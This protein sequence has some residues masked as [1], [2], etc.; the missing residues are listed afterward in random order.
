MEHTNNSYAKRTKIF[1]M[2]IFLVISIFTIL[3]S[4]NL[5]NASN[6]YYQ[7]YS[8]NKCCYFN[9]GANTTLTFIDGKTCVNKFLSN[10]TFITVQSTTLNTLV[11]AGGGGG[12]GTTDAS[13]GGGAGGFQT[14]IITNLPTNSYS[15][16]VGLGGPKNG[17]GYNSSFYNITSIGGGRG[18][19]AYYNDPGNGGSGGGAS[20]LGSTGAYGANGTVGQ[21][22]DGGD[23][24]HNPGYCGGGGGG[25]GAGAEGASMPVCGT[26]G[27]G[28]AGLQSNITGVNTYYAGGGGASA[29]SNIGHGGLGGGGDGVLT[30]AGYPGINGTGG[31]GGA[32]RGS[33][34]GV[35]GSGIVVLSYLAGNMPLQTIL[36]S[37]LNDSVTVINNY[38][39]QFT[40]EPN[41][42]NINNWTF[43]IWYPNN[44]I[45]NITQVTGLSTPTT[46]NI[47]NNV[48]ISDGDGYLWNVQACGINGATTIC[49]WGIYNRTFSVNAGST[50]IAIS[51]GS[52]IYN[53][54]ST[55]VNHTVNYTITNAH[56]N[57]C[58]LTYN[59]VNTTIPCVNGV[60]K[61]INFSLANGIYT[62]TIYT[63]DTSGNKLH[64]TFSWSYKIF[65]NSRTYNNLTYETAGETFL[66]DITAANSSLLTS[67][68]LV[69][70]GTTRTSTLTGSVWNATFDIPTQT[71]AADKSF[72]WNFIYDGSSIDSTN[73]NIQTVYPINFSFCN[74]PNDIT[75][76]NFTYK[77]EMQYFSINAS[78]PAATFNYWLGTGSVQKNYFFT[79]TEENSSTKFCFT[80]AN[81]TLN[82]NYLYQATSAGYI[83]RTFN[84][85]SNLTLYNTSTSKLFYL[86]QSADAGPVTIQVVDLTSGNVISN[87]RVTITRD[88]QGVTVTVLDGYTDSAGT[89]ATYLSSVVSY[90]ITASKSGCGTNTQTITPVGSYNIQLNCAGT[91]T[92]YVSNINGVTYQHTPNVG[93][94]LLPGNITFGY[95]V[96]S[97]FYPIISSRFELYDSDGTLLASNITDVSSNYSWCNAKNCTTTIRYYTASGDSIKGRYYVNLGNSTNNTYILL[98]KDAYWRYIYVNT[99]NSQQAWQKA[100]MHFQDWMNVWGNQQ[101]NC[102]VYSTQ[103]TCTANPSCKW[104][105]TTEW[106]P[107]A[108]E[109]YTRAVNFCMLKDDVNKME[110]NRMLII[111][112]GIVVVLFIM[113]RGIGYEMTNPGSFVLFLSIMILILSMG[114]LFTFSGLTPWDWFNQYIYAYICLT[115]AAGYNLSII[116][117]YSM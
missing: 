24:G 90:T 22:Y 2:M 20:I 47:L 56:L 11:V 106:D 100:V 10:G 17:S 50:S 28:G 59:G 1:G 85:I 113:G 23:S 81:R 5:I 97:A 4:L 78:V 51:S 15:V 73:S 30:G 68:S 55:Y 95:Y 63:N 32:G 13:G 39:F 110:F 84:S 89:I 14:F 79:T 102:I 108:T 114:G 96:S 25:G 104:L 116:R 91:L 31:G 77:D 94:S 72:Y 101:T 3:L 8:L 43:Y 103:S 45:F 99:N 41:N 60:L 27:N 58:W 93:I 61:S 18:G 112:F 40:I 37:P 87:A 62:A 109:N 6:E 105:N 64:N 88:I 42:T 92:P 46:L 48:I 82:L 16:V 53:Y 44:T 38:D 19:N 70:N 111:F 34:G 12:G 83:T 115:F 75:Y 9:S 117:R 98:E 74:P 36:N 7:C 57:N 65:E 67:A 49:N 107:R 76:L 71:I 52:G 69:W 26:G 86:I 21:G 35:G 29:D 54:G 80:P 66:T 33:G